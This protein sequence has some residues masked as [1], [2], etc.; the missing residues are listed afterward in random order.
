MFSTFN[1]KSIMQA[2]ISDSSSE[3][4]S[5]ARRTSETATESTADYAKEKSEAIRKLTQEKSIAADK[6]AI[7]KHLHE[8][9][10]IGK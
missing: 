9:L 10:S 7:L 5:E 8:C 4:S 6:I 2:I 1:R 3:S